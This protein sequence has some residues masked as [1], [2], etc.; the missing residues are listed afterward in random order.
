MDALAGSEARVA[1]ELNRLGI[2][3][4]VRVMPASTRSAAEAAAALGCDVSQIV[5]SL[6][7]RSIKS[8]EPILVLASGANRVDENRLAEI[9]QAPV[10]RAT[11]E[12]VRARTGYAIGGVPPVAHLERID[13]YLDE[14]LLSHLVV[15]AAAGSPRAV[16]SLT[17]TE[18]VRVTEAT[19]VALAA[20]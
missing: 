13:A 4:E 8:D 17:P 18:L 15:W 12:F 20:K 14:H 16:F 7:F 9:V 10:Q 2:T 5:K 6:I 19:V 11:A 1:E 3:S